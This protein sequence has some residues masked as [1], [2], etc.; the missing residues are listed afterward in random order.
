[1]YTIKFKNRKL[2]NLT[3]FTYEE[4]RS[5]LRAILRQNGYTNRY[6]NPSISGT[7]YTIVRIA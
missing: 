2:K 6:R 1:M 3:F 4:A 7:G 5:A